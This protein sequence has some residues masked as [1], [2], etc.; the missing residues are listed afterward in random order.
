MDTKL[1]QYDLKLTI[2]TATD[3]MEFII[4]NSCFLILQYY[5]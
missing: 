5:F 4:D 2:E 1:L 3:S